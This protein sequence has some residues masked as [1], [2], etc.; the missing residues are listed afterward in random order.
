LYSGTVAA[1]GEAALQGIPSIALSLAGPPFPFDE[2]AQVVR[3]FVQ[4]LKDKDFGTDTFLNV[5]LPPT[6]VGQADWRATQLG[7]RGF[8]D[9]FSAR[10]DT[11]GKTY[12]RYG[13]EE[14]EEIGGENTDVRTVRNGLVSFTPLRYRFTNDK[15]IDT[16][17]S[18]LATQPTASN[19]S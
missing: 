11:A 18:W 9:K 4:L 2:A 8:T 1:A 13:G 3:R 5:N 7:A 16:L 19:R 14:L 17:T 6:N 12:F 10:V 15:M